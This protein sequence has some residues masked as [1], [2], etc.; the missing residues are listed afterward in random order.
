[1]TEI[2]ITHRTTIE[3]DAPIRAAYHEARLTP[4]TDATQTVMHP[5]IAVNPQPWATTYRD[6]WGATVTAF[7][8]L[9]PHESLTVT[10]TSTVRLSPAPATGSGLGWTELADPVLTDR[11]A[12]FLT[13]TDRVRPPADVARR[14]EQAVASGATPAEVAA[15]AAGVADTHLVIGALRH[16][17]IPARYV[18]GYLVDDGG[19]PYTWAEWWDGHWTRVSPEPNVVALATGRDEGDVPGLRALFTGEASATTSVEVELER[20]S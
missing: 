19:S 7:E 14:A 16:V 20:I 17:G 2:R 6:Y 1:M 18:T 9:H 3:Y 13:V 10:A 8:V 12:E 15:E 4:L 11:L 5:H